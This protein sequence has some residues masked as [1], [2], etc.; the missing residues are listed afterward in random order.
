M[1]SLSLHPPWKL[2]SPQGQAKC[3]LSDTPLVPPLH[4]S[5]RSP[6]TGNV[7]QLPGT[8]A[9]SRPTRLST[10]IPN[11]STNRVF[12]ATPTTAA[13]P[14]ATATTTTTAVS[15]TASIPSESSYRIWIPV[16]VHPARTIW[17]SAC[18]GNSQPVRY[19]D[20][21][22]RNATDG[23]SASAIPTAATTAAASTCCKHSYGSFKENFH[24]N[25]HVCANPQW[26]VPSQ[27][28][29]DIQSDLRF[30]QLQTK[31]SLSSSF[32]LP[33]AVNRH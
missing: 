21:A 15:T 27:F 11:P 16:S 4:I 22:D 32:D 10:S 5:S 26:S 12:T 28:T 18:A 8:A 23:L 2:E 30:S 19:A 31:S 1:N 3:P 6:C 9:A 33:L 14:R 29:T 13:A 25:G 17:C 24:C 20:T 7:Q